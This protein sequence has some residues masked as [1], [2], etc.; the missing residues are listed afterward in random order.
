MA[1]LEESMTLEDEPVRYRVSG[2]AAT[3]EDGPPPEGPGCVDLKGDV[4]SVHAK[5]RYYDA[6]I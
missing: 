3:F 4:R 1:F 2:P 6:H 5:A